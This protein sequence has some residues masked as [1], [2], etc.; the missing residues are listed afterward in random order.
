MRYTIIKNSHLGIGLF[1]I[2]LIISM[3]C[4]NELLE[5]LPIKI[6]PAIRLI[7]CIVL[8]IIMFLNFF[9][10]KIG[11][12]IISLFYSS[13]WTIAIWNIVKYFT[14]N[15]KIWMIVISGF[16]FLLIIGIHFSICLDSGYDYEIFHDNHV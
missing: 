4:F 12:A 7:I 6:H 9:S 10:S 14:D 8:G 11:C 2:E 1:V 16:A 3:A 15:D 13:V 5:L